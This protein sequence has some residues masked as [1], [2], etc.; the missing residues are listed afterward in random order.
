M[1]TQLIWTVL[2]RFLRPSG[3]KTFLHLS[4]F[5]S[6]RID[7][8]APPELLDWPATLGKLKFKF[9]FITDPGNA[10]LPAGPAADAPQTHT[11]ERT[12]PMLAA[13]AKPLWD[14]LLGSARVQTPTVRPPAPSIPNWDERSKAQQ[15]Q[16]LY[17]GETALRADLAKQVD[18]PE[19]RD[20]HPTFTKEDAER[21]KAKVERELGEFHKRFA[22]LLDHDHL[23]RLM[24][25]VLPFDFEDPT[26]SAGRST[27]FVRVRI[28]GSLPASLVPFTPWTAFEKDATYFLPRPRTPGPRGVLP[29]FPDAFNFAQFNVDAAL[30]S[31]KDTPVDRLPPLKSSGLALNLAGRDLKAAMSRGNELRE[32]L[33]HFEATADEAQRAALLNTSVVFAEDVTRGYGIDVQSSDPGQWESLCTRIPVYKM[34]GLDLRGT[35]TEG[36]IAPTVTE[37]PTGTLLPQPTLFNWVGWSLT[38]PHLGKEVPAGPTDLFKV[39]YELPRPLPA[40]LRF[41]GRYRFR[42]RRIDLAGC[43]TP[44]ESIL[45]AEVSGSATHFVDYRRFEP[46]P[47]PIFALA[48]GD[49]D[50][51]VILSK[52]DGVK[53]RT[54]A[55]RAR[56][57]PPP[58]THELCVLH[59]ELETKASQAKAS[60]RLDSS[61]RPIGF[62]QLG[63]GL[64][65]FPDPAAKSV[66]MHLTSEKLPALQNFPGVEL[67]D[68]KALGCTIDGATGAEP[69]ISADPT[70]FKVGVPKGRSLII[71]LSSP[72]GA[73]DSELF[74]LKEWRAATWKQDQAER[75][76]DP[77]ISP[78]HRVQA[79]HA[80]QVPLVAPKFMEAEAKRLP[81][82]TSASMSFTTHLD[83][84]STDRLDLTA[85]WTEVNDDVLTEAE[86]EVARTATLDPKYFEP[87]TELGIVAAPQ[88]LELRQHF[89]DTRGRKVSY[90]AKAWSRFAHYFPNE[91]VTSRDSEREIVC[92][93]PSSAAPP[94]PVVHS[95]VP[96]FGW[97]PGTAGP[98]TSNRYGRG[99]RLYFERPWF[100]SGDGELLGV[101]VAPSAQDPAA[102]LRDHEFRTSF[103]ASD[104]T[105]KLGAPTPIVTA[106]M[107]DAR[108]VTRVPFT[109]APLEVIAMRPGTH[110]VSDGRWL[111]CVDLAFAH[112]AYFPFVRLA[113]VRYQPNAIPGAKFSAIV[114]TEFAQIAPD[115][116]VSCSRE[117]SAMRVNLTGVAASSTVE[118]VLEQ[119]IRGH[120]FPVATSQLEPRTLGDRVHW[121]SRV[122]LRGKG[123]YRLVFI[124]RESISQ[125]RAGSEFAKAEEGS[126]IIHV[127][128]LPFTV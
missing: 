126:R 85:S 27:G 59:G 24:G 120:R 86:D 18:T 22:L 125:D 114:L 122:P 108:D 6:P 30:H 87:G 96:T 80:T 47:P 107:L 97:S 69:T 105:Q 94:V 52:W 119:K 91:K 54:A 46:I 35:E 8:T 29:L 113:L 13:S 1:P 77:M 11:N 12:P 36:A 109:T 51:I 32:V 40:K 33:T 37:N 10:P 121:S 58:A 82:E 20:T 14:H 127:D 100:A 5:V 16:K 56:I 19:Y 63:G 112:D 103:L 92:L 128:Q 123:E 60:G 90:S 72:V 45:D 28:T 88:V 31:L 23:L 99:L 111:R 43:A 15:L 3:G 106:D 93:V 61:K 48:D 2:P 9:D 42:A 117:D 53:F 98:L 25:L 89:G 79:V 115:R 38:I 73:R 66:A 44:P 104:F 17:S 4:V 118:V 71:E 41:G 62:D 68:R 110:Q 84:P 70:G 81:N 21:L 116:F 124:E 74:G 102:L 34:A 76:L 95:V 78:I 26:G 7:G 50:D 39:S 65:Y 49:A 64:G 57:G 83:P 101:I 55:V 75:G 67:W